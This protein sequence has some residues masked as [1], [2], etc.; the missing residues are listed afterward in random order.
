MNINLL[1]CAHEQEAFI[2]AFKRRMPRSCEYIEVN[3]ARRP[4]DFLEGSDAVIIIGL[5]TR[6]LS[7]DDYY[8]LLG[9]ISKRK[10][11]IVAI[12]SE[13]EN[14]PRGNQGVKVIKREGRNL[15]SIVAELKNF[16][17]IPKDLV[18]STEG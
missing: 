17:K 13:I 10:I 9:I 11:P 7:K 3:E 8:S 1:Y 6:I 5:Y 12:I 18:Y 14:L 2:E 16:L 4:F 15:E